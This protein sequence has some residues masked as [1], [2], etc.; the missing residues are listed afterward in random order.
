MLRKAMLLALT[1]APLTLA[2]HTL[3]AQ[4]RGRGEE[5]RGGDG[6]PRGF[7]TFPA[8]TAAQ[9]R[10]MPNHGGRCCC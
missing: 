8:A 4:E 9:E 6:R 5:G 1:L 2:P 3:A 7:P 10:N